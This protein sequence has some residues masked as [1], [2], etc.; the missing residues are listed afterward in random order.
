MDE[1]FWLKDHCHSRK[2][3]WWKTKHSC[4]NLGSNIAIRKIGS[5]LIRF[6]MT[7]RNF[8]RS[9]APWSFFSS[10]SLGGAGRSGQN[11]ILHSI[12]YRAVED[13]VQW[14]LVDCQRYLWGFIHWK[15]LS[16]FSLT[17]RKQSDFAY[18]YLLYSKIINLFI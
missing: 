3:K 17:I 16:I 13:E 5:R 11:A 4:Q 12:M 2:K 6:V 7:S 1:A 15:R 10:N 14:R 9:S 18:L 8:M